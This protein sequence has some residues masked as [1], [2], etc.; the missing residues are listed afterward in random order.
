MH[1]GADNKPERADT[2]GGV[3]EQPADVIS[4]GLADVFEQ[5]AAESDF[6]LESDDFGGAVGRVENTRAAAEQGDAIT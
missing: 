3:S 5:D 6:L 1:V 4:E 2:D